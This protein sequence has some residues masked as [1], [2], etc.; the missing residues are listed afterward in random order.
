MLSSEKI[1]ANDAIIAN[2]FSFKE[3]KNDETR[4]DLWK[5]SPG[6]VMKKSALY[7]AIE[8][9][10]EDIVK[11]LLASP[12]IDVNAIYKNN[13]YKLGLVENGYKWILQPKNQSP[14]HIAVKNHN[15]EIIKL[16]LESQKIDLNVVD[17]QNKKAIDY[18]N[19][20]EIK[21]FL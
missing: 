3:N 7:I 2:I 19:D 1:D 18:A 12:S 20:D 14:L 21:L 4:Q 16:L 8:N 9:N 13:S 17:D 15:I 10:D 5:W 11:L 6:A